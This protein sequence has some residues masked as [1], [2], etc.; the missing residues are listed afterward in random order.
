M[1]NIEIKMLEPVSM[2]KNNLKKKL[3]VRNTR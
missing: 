2:R 1:W 3:L